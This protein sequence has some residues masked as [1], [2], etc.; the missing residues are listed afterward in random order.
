MGECE[1]LDWYGLYREGW[2]DQLPPQAFVHPESFTGAMSKGD[3]TRR[4]AGASSSLLH[5]P[6]TDYTRNLVK[7]FP[8]TSSASRL[9]ACVD[10]ERSSAFLARRGCS[11]S[12]ISTRFAAC[13]T[14]SRAKFFRV[15]LVTNERCTT[16]LASAAHFDPASCFVVF[17][18][19]LVAQELW[20][21]FK[22]QIASSLHRYGRN[23][24]VWILFG[25]HGSN[26]QSPSFTHPASQESVFSL[27][28]LFRCDADAGTIPT[29]VVT[30]ETGKGDGVFDL[31]QVQRI[32]YLAPSPVNKSR[33]FCQLRNRDSV[34]SSSLSSLSVS[35]VN[36]R[37]PLNWARCWR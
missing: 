13:R 5:G 8:A 12:F 19:K 11:S 14:M 4:R 29:S 6:A 10:D 7:W 36:V 9:T 23:P 28:E 35:F 33:K 24:D 37:T 32:N 27:G 1:T 20:S 26:G 2:G 34:K 16:E 22:T 18:S 25:G 3:A 17:W 30:N 15:T 21:K 31:V